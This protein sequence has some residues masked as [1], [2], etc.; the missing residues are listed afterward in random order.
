MDRNACEYIVKN[1]ESIEA[2]I[3]IDGSGQPLAWYS[4]KES[5]IDEVSS[6]SAALFAVARELNLFDTSSNA[7]TVFESSFGAL[8]LKAIDNDSLLVLCLTEGFS[9]FTIDRLLKRFFL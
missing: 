7:S 3:V 4:R 2:A 1:A 6:I 5:S 8:A 9:F